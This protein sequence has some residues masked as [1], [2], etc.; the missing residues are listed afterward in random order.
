MA[1][2]LALVIGWSAVGH[3]CRVA[4]DGPKKAHWGKESC[5][6]CRMAVSDPTSAAQLVG[7]DSTARFYDDLGCA[8]FD[9][10]SRPKLKNAK[11]YVVAP[12]ER[13]RFVPAESVR[14]K[15]KTHTPMDYGFQ[16][17][18]DGT[19]TI[20]EVVQT[21]MDRHKARWGLSRGAK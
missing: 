11:L 14:Y 20:S 2:T 9:W 13:D 16:A 10:V 5:A 18:R 6:T 17:A 21:L 4:D 15:D 19:L 8:V 12:G 7:P 3:A 1:L